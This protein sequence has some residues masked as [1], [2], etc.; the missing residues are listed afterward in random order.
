VQTGSSHGGVV[1]PDGTIAK[2]A[3]AFETLEEMSRVAREE[4]GMAGAVQHGASTLPDELFHRF[5]EVGTA[6]IHLATNFQTMVF[7]SPVFPESLR[8]EIDAYLNNLDEWKEGATEAQSS[9]RAETRHRAI[10][11]ADVGPAEDV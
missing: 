7:D 2:V 9:Q 3:I 4:Y 6:E 1:L 5:V 8:Q 11:A 10:Q